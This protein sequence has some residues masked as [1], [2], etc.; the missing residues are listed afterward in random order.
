[1][2]GV[3]AS[4]IDGDGDSPV[5]LYA[6]EHV[7]QIT[8]VT[9]SF[10]GGLNRLYWGS[11]SGD[12]FYGNLDG[13][14]SP[15][16]LYENIK[17]KWDSEIGTVLDFAVNEDSGELL[18][19]TIDGL[20]LAASDGSSPYFTKVDAGRIPAVEI[21]PT[22]GN[23]YYGGIRMEHE[24]GFVKFM[25]SP[26]GL[27]EPR[28]MYSWHAEDPYMNK[29]FPRGIAIDTHSGYLY[30]VDNNHVFRGLLDGTSP[31]L[32][33][34]FEQELFENNATDE[35]GTTRVRTIDFYKDQLY[36]GGFAE[37]PDYTTIWT[38]NADGSGI[39]EVLYNITVF[40]DEWRMAGYQVTGIRG[41]VIRNFQDCPIRCDS[42]KSETTQVFP[43]STASALPAGVLIFRFVFNVGWPRDKMGGITLNIEQETSAEPVGWGP[44]TT[45]AVDVDSWVDGTYTVLKD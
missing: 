17:D 12:V 41:L 24:T 18:L 3:Y 10:C 7:S 33:V 42:A 26:F 16:R 20:Y 8:G 40:N 36:I 11:P 6:T 32:E 2:G 27:E 15:V 37:D 1:M 19:G 43:L 44:A 35:E 14:G 25:R 39:P 9:A 4:T 22:S 23:V 38:V 34:H 29:D 30:V 28:T 31:L 45:V 5:K 21:D 13:S